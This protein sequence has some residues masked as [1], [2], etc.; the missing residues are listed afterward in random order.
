MA[1]AVLLACALNE[2]PGGL[3]GCLL[4]LFQVAL[5]ACFIPLGD[6]SLG[7]LTQ[8]MCLA[9][10]EVALTAGVQQG[11]YGGGLRPISCALVQG[12]P[13]QPCLLL[14]SRAFQR[15]QCGFGAVEQPGFEKVQRQGVLGAIAV[16]TREVGTR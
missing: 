5:G 11:R 12:Q 8:V 14:K 2:G 9:L 1:L 4:G 13:C 16:S 10:A 15:L 7:L 6:G 3:G